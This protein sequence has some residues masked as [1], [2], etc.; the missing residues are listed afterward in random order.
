MNESEFRSWRAYFPVRAMQP[1]NS[2]RAY[3]PASRPHALAFAF[4]VH[5]IL[6]VYTYD[7]CLPPSSLR[8]LLLSFL[9]A[10]T[11]DPSSWPLL[12]RLPNEQEADRL[13][14]RSSTTLWQITSCASSF[15]FVPSPPA[16]TRVSRHA[17]RLQQPQEGAAAAA[18]TA[19]ERHWKQSSSS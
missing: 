13:N 7:F 17:A 16:P 11:V 8:L 5:S 4:L 10:T 14:V 18:Q 3:C 6:L 9:H 19:L 1:G 15:F 2:S 12:R